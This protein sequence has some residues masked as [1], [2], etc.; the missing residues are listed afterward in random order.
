MRL[1]NH[2]L[3]ALLDDLESDRAEHK[4]SVSDRQKIRQAICAF[5][6]DLPGHGLPGV[7]FVG[8]CDDGSCAGL[9]VTDELLRRLADMRD[10][11][12]ILPL[13][14]MSVEKRI[15]RGCE[16]AVVT[17]APA[18]AP[19]VRLQGR[20]WIRVGPRRATATV[21][22][23]RRLAE[24]RQAADLPYELDARSYASLDDLDLILFERSYL[25]AAVAPDVLAQNER[26][27]THQLKALRFIDREGH[28]TILGLL[29]VGKDPPSFVH[30]AYIQFVRFQGTQLSDPIRNQKEIRG[31]LPDLMRRI[32]EVLEANI[33]VATSITEG[34]LEIRRPDYPLAALQQL[35][36]NAVLH[37][38]YQGTNAPVRCYWFD[39]RI[40]IHN[41]GGAYG[42]V[43]AESFGQADV[44]DY[45]NPHLAEAMKVLELVQRFGVGITIARKELEK[46]DN[47]PPVFNVQPS[48]V[49]A[50]VRRRH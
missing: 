41:P 48:Y 17:V 36:R 18:L 13:P 1:D 14:T 12:G 29:V 38:S 46:N 28:P 37:R 33:E 43:T 8:A 42:Q 23:E 3:E 26:S 27:L 22:E 30:G 31:P 19:P 5:A 47:P 20:T 32:D 50:T 9:G 11:G 6:N 34:P 45:R 24:R 15:V 4:E 44:T 39:D 2:E 49:L 35:V 16:L 40:E 10:N 21:E 7:L 25:Q